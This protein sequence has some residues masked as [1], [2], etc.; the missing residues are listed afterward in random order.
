MQQLGLTGELYRGDLL[1]PN[2]WWIRD[3]ATTLKV[4]VC[5]VYY[6]ATHGWIHSRKTRSGKHWILWAD[7]DELKRLE[8]LKV[9]RNSYTARRNHK[10]TTPKARKL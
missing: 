4:P 9:Q 2:E 3:L 6:W 1:G 7:D 5:K 10:L 8:K